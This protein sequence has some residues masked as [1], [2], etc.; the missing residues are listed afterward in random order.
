VAKSPFKLVKKFVPNRD[1]AKARLVKNLYRKLWFEHANWLAQQD[2]QNNIPLKPRAQ[3]E[4][5]AKLWARNE[6]S[7][8]KLPMKYAVSGSTVLGAEIMGADLVGA[9]WN[10]F[11]WFQSQVN[12]TLNSTAGQRA[13]QAP[14]EQSAEALQPGDMDTNLQDPSA[15]SYPESAPEEYTDEAGWNGVRQVKAPHDP[16]ADSLGA[17][18]AHVLGKNLPA[19]DNQYVDQIVA[20]IVAKLRTGQEISP[21]EVGLL[22][23]AAKEGNERARKVVAVLRE[24]GAVVSGDESG[25]DPW[26]YKLNPTYW[27]ASSRKKAFID[28]ERKG[29]KEN[30]AL[31]EKLDEQLKDLSAAERAARA[32]EAVEQARAQSAETEKQLKAIAD[33]LKGS[34]AGSFVGHEDV[35]AMSEIVKRVLAKTG[36]L[37]TATRLYAKVKAGESLNEQ[38]LREARQIARIVGKTRVVHGGLVND[39]DASMHGTFVGACTLGGITVALDQNLKH[40]QAAGALSQRAA[41]GRPLSQEDRDGLARVLHGQQKIKKLTSSLV[42]GRALRGCPESWTRGAFVGA[43]KA[44]DPESRKMLAAIVKLAKVG[45]PRAQKALALLRKTGEIS[46]GDDVGLSLKSAFKYATAPVWLPAAGLYKGGKWLGK[47]TGLISKGK[48]SPE[49]VRLQKLRAAQKRAAAAQARARAA[50]SQNEAEYRAQQAI[51]AAA[52]A[53]ADAADAEATAKE[54]AMRTAE[55][56]AAPDLAQDEGDSDETQGELIGKDTKG[57]KAVAKSREKSPAGQKVRG[58]AKVY[59]RAKAGDPKARR[60]IEVMVDKANQGDQQALRDVNTMKVARLAYEAEQAAKKQRLAARKEA[61]EKRVAAQKEKAR[62]ARL[63]AN[64]KKFEALRKKFEA[65]TAERLARMERKRSLQKLAKVERRAA[66]G[67]PKAKKIVASKVE[68][69]K[70]G[71]KKAQG[72]VKAMELTKQTRQYQQSHRTTWRVE[73][74][75]L[76]AARYLA[77]GIL[78]NKPGAIR[79]YEVIKA[80]AAQG[81]PN[82]KR[83]LERIELQLAVLRTIQTGTVTLPKQ[84]PGAKAKKP[85]YAP[86]KKQVESAREKAMAGTATREELIASSRLAKEI[87]DMSSAGTLAEAAAS[88]PSATE[89]V[90]KAAARVAAAQANNPEARAQLDRDLSAAHKGDADAVNKLGQ[91]A[92]AKTIAAV[93]KGQPVPPVMRDAVNL[94]ERARAGDPVAQETLQRV[95]EAATSPDPSPEAT[96]AAVY[97]T[98]AAALASSLASKPKARQEF[99]AKVN[100]PVPP[101]EQAAAQA[102]LTTI[103]QKVNEGVV[104]PAESRQGVELAMRLGKPRVAAEISAKSPP[105]PD[106]PLPPID[107]IW[108]LFIASLKA[109]TFMT[110]DPFGNYHEGVSA[111]AS[112][113]TTSAGDFVGWSPFRFFM[114]AKPMLPALALLSAPVTAVATVAN[115]V[116]GKKGSPAPT[117]KADLKTPALPA[118]QPNTPSV[119]PTTAAGAGTGN[120]FR[121]VVATALKSKK[122]SRRDLDRAV[123]SNPASRKSPAAKKALGEQVRKFLEDHK[124][125]VSGDKTPNSEVTVFKI[126]VAKAIETKKMSRE[127]FNK[128]VV[129]N[130]KPTATK[131][132]KTLAAAHLLRFLE[133]RGVK[134]V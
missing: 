33:S 86:A 22:S 45:N 114:R 115:L 5:V 11:S 124:V 133:K 107:G 47:K 129:A 53:E 44:S 87:G 105:A 126:L 102:Q 65:R 58:A 52:D 75:N 17:F 32:A 29:W 132:E 31:R 30:A 130:L 119:P 71:D 110:P 4:S 120:T 97:A 13:D 36:K 82:A 54:Q 48:A 127:D 60:A 16:V 108:Q 62:K 76:K 123:D 134:I 83:G 37:E 92:A 68:A 113:V 96:T 91:V 64:E 101:P 40:Q 15:Q 18:A 81:N 9:W 1:K 14:E 93:E 69:A 131:D 2:K 39:T 42:S 77:K 89:G 38:E 57:A 79:Q 34:M 90:K 78:A 12:V 109:L 10:P 51:A 112:R 43:A 19:K 85:S 117:A 98:G 27:F 100:E 116:K 49:Q 106:Q 59:H 72:Q 23:S 41:S 74:K 122:I 73:R 121:D 66:A 3:Y 95:S 35:T 63:N 84:K 125:I 104:T 67:D 50:D 118:A 111:R 61:K 56:E 128:T 24:R 8:R 6:I 80:A 103:V 99:M 7:K 88:A 55:I 20:K 94:Q 28:K 26:M 25:L 46:G 21:G 70:R